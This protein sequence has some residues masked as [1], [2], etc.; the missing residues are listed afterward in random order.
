MSHLAGLTRHQ[1]QLAINNFVRTSQV[2]KL[3]RQ[4]A[5][6]PTQRYIHT[7]CTFPACSH[8]SNQIGER[9]NKGPKLANPQGLDIYILFP[10]ILAIMCATTETRDRRYHGAAY[11]GGASL[12]CC[13]WL[14][15][16][17]ALWAITASTTT[18]SAF[19]LNMVATHGAAT[20]SS[21]RFRSRTATTQ[22]RAPPLSPPTPPSPAVVGGGGGGVT[23]SLISNLAVA[24]LKL[25]LA[26]H[27][28][29]SC[30]V[31]GSSAADLLLRGTVGPVTVRGRGWS[32]QLG[33]TC[34]AIDATVNRCHLDMGSVVSRRKL[35]LT[36][37]AKG[38]ALI[39]LNG[40]DFANF[41]KHPLMKPPALPGSDE[42][43]RFL[44]EDVSIDVT[45][46]KGGA[47]IFHGEYMERRWRCELRR[48]WGGR[49]NGSKG[50]LVSVKPAS[51][52]G[53]ADGEREISARLTEILSAFFNEMVFELDGTYLSFKDMMV[54]SK[55][56][57]PSVMLALS[58]TVKKFPSAGLAF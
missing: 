16:L 35:V 48:G 8:N 25:R 39:A 26:D 21:S 52:E 1:R 22:K 15:A 2:P 24:A 44:K 6:L 38:D 7:S 45:S 58:I 23:S 13:S 11:N 18:C 28:A 41:I 57:A 30:D 32:S 4:N 55:G 27:S 5:P 36:T 31:T 54:T 51:G 19:Q 49:N 17:L 47:V 40:A 34:R 50:A 33:L 42:S 29:V 53:A 9:P 43:F 10:R 20:R 14:I 12:R 56:D 3:P 37:P 46:D